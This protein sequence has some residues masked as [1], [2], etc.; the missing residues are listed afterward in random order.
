MQS[1]PSSPELARTTDQDLEQMAASWRV[2]AGRG[3]RQAFGIA[4]ALEVELRRR[5]KTRLVEDSP[6]ESP[7]RT[8]RWRLWNSW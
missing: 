4:H 2:K 7:R 5:V 1:I 6:R 3:Q 8:T